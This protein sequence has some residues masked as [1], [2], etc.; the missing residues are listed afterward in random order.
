MNLHR[1]RARF[2]YASLATNEQRLS[3]SSK[4]N[5]PALGDLAKLSASSEQEEDALQTVM[6]VLLYR[7]ARRSAGTVVH[8]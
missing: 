2:G 6:R 8:R 7:A 5:D 3:L 4:P 1:V